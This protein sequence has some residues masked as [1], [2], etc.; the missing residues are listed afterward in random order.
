[1]PQIHHDT[2]ATPKLGGLTN[3]DFPVP[4]AMAKAAVHAMTMSLAVE[5]ARYG[6]RLIALAPA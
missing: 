2:N 1:M 6:I 5:S 3:G 4:S